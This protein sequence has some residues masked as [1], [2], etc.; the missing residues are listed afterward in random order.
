[1]PIGITAKVVDMR[2]DFRPENTINSGYEMW[3]ANGD[4][5]NLSITRT[6]KNT[7]QVIASDAI[8]PTS[9]YI[10]S[11]HTIAGRTTWKFIV[12]IVA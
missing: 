3:E 9:S 7:Y 1:L 12:D 5:D 4:N 6:G 10:D 2:I 8:I 11:A